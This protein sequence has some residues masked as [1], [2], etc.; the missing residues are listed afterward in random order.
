MVLQ[1]C[2]LYQLPAVLLSRQRTACCHPQAP[3][4][5][6]LQHCRWA[7]RLLLCPDRREAAGSRRQTHQHQTA[8]Q[9][10]RLLVLVLAWRRLLAGCCLTGGRQSL[11]RAMPLSSLQACLRLCLWSRLGYWLAA[12]C[13]MQKGGWWLR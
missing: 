4:P 8:W 13:L 2:L 5:A 3:Y 11:Q 12:M 7:S 1:L 9:A 6:L 10:L